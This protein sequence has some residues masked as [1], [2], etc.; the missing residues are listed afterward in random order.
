M[1]GYHALT[2][3]AINLLRKFQELLPRCGSEKGGRGRNRA[4]TGRSELSLFFLFPVNSIEW[5]FSRISQSKGS[6]QHPRSSA[7]PLP[8]LSASRLLP[9]GSGSLGIQPR[10][11]S[12]RS[13]YTGLYP[14]ISGHPTRGCIPRGSGAAPVCGPLAAHARGAPPRP[15]LRVVHLGRST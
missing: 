3:S 6:G 2:L 11:K 14:Q 4:V 12:L 9:C 7:P 5:L 8:S 13:S 1:G 10:V 15:C